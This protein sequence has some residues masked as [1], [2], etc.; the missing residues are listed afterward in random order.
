M[1]TTRDPAADSEFYDESVRAWT[2]LW[3]S[4]APDTQM[5]DGWT[6]PWLDTSMRDANPIF[7][8]CAKRLAI[9]V[10]VIQHDDEDSFESWLHTFAEG[11]AD[12]I[13]ELV[14]SCANTARH[15]S[16]ARQLIES[17]IERRGAEASCQWAA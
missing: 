4:I 12:A 13:H 16:I 17:W 7:S 2:E 3:L 5:I 10:R 11:T 8:A 9:G 15:R 14:I 6:T 1:A